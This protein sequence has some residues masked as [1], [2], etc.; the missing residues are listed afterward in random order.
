MARRTC[1][2]RP[3]S[4]A[5]VRNRK[6]PYARAESEIE[7]KPIDNEYTLGPIAATGAA[8]AVAALPPG[9]SLGLPDLGRAWRELARRLGARDWTPPLAAVALVASASAVTW[10]DG[11]AWTPDR[12]LL[13]FLAPALVLRRGRR[14]LG[15]FVP[16]AL[17]IFA[18]AESRGLAHLISPHPFYRPQLWLE[19]SIFGT[20]PAQWL[21][22]HFWR[23]TV[24]W[25]DGVAKQLLQLHFVVPPL[26]AFGLWVKRR[27]LFFRFAAS[28]VVLSFAAAVVFA[29][30]PAAPPWA[31]GKAG[32]LP[33]VVKLPQA[34]APDV[35]SAGLSPH[36][37]SV[38]S[39]IP[40]N[41]YA[42][43][44]SLHAGYAFLV[45][46]T[47]ASL[48]LRRRG[49]FR[50]PLVAL[51]SLYPLLQA[52]AVVYTGNHYVIDIVIGFVFA[53]AAFVVTNRFWKRLGLPG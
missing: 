49:R 3:V 35:S 9:K 4:R 21:Q 34:S 28:M 48:L 25:Y 43:I 24:H 18:Y 1:P 23:G 11:L 2:L 7:H 15:D 8:E 12:M 44:P 40:G 53:S 46:L 31:A 13:V 20:V 47:I 45:F 5:I 30:F 22:E 19:Q 42:A 50:W 14:Y 26:L 41:P 39:V 29:A 51:C 36:T 27:T 10:S 32:Y 52:L 16:F 38:S 37:F 6:P 33:H 17:L